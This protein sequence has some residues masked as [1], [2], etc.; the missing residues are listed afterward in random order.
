MLTGLYLGYVLLVSLIKP[1]WVP[2]LPTEARTIREDDGTPGL[3]SLGV[4][5]VLSVGAAIVFAQLAPGRA[6]RPTN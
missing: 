2:A 6:R 3:R 1:Q 4:L 5:F